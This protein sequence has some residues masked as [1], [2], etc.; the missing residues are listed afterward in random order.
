M[1][2]GVFFAKANGNEMGG[3]KGKEGGRGS[4]ATAR[5]SVGPPRAWQE[6]P[7]CKRSA[8]TPAI[9]FL[10]GREEAGQT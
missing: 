3:G 9:H 8:N 7:A 2:C 6:T 1:R 5:H 10:Q 4:A